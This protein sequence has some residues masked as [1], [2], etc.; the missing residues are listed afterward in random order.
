[1][2]KRFEQRWQSSL[3]LALGLSGPLTWM[4]GAVLGVALCV[5][6]ALCQSQQPPRPPASENAGSAVSANGGA[7]SGQ[8]PRE[9]PTGSISGTV[10]DQN[11]AGVGGAQVAF[12]RGDE[13]ATQQAVSDE[14]GQ[15][16]F[17]NI[18]PGPFRLTITAP[19]FAPQAVSGALHP[20]EAYSAARI[21]LALAGVV[22]QVRVMPTVE[23][24]EAQIKDQEKQR[25]LGVVPNFYVT[26]V[27][28]AAPLDTKQKFELAWHSTIDP[29]TIGFVGATAGVQQAANQYP[30]YGQGAQGYGRRFGAAYADVA[31][32]TFLGGAILPSLFKQ[33]PRFFYKGTGS[34]RSRVLYALETSVMCKGDNGHWQLD[35]SGIA[36][37]LAAGGISNL[38]YPPQDRDDLAVTFES[39]AIG[40]GATAAENI[41][42]EFVVPKFTRKKG[43]RAVSPGGPSTP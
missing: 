23:M 37:S 25:V 3:P 32:S 5:S 21:Q 9:Q 11:G 42:Q 31:I 16:F 41:L 34:K 4:S 7:I 18:A 38:Y 43:Q 17:V 10:V 39:T 6:P 19:G 8:N 15:F 12:A 13:R 2:I 1:M 35:Y 27:P 20:G 14:A 30:G 22:T 33:D 29:V 24:A 40:I 26:Y 36:G 28:D